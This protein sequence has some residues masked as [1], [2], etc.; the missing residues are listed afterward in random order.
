MIKTT[1]NPYINKFE[2]VDEM[3]DFQKKKNFLP[4]YFKGEKPYLLK[5]KTKQPN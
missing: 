5:N 4:N 3:H 1:M 2:N